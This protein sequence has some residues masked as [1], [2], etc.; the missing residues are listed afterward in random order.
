[1]EALRF[2]DVLLE[3]DPG[4]TPVKAPLHNA[5]E[6]WSPFCSHTI[7]KYNCE[8]AQKVMISNAQNTLFANNGLLWMNMSNIDEIVN[9]FQ[10]YFSSSDIR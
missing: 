4:F 2:F 5:F 8:N 6:S 3:D 9:S 1:M 7:W 10:S